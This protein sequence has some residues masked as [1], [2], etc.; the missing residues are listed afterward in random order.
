MSDDLRRLLLAALAALLVTLP[1]LW[2]LGELSY[3]A[4][5]S[6]THKF[7][8]GVRSFLAYGFDRW[9]QL[10]LVGVYVSVTLLQELCLHH[11]PAARQRL[12]P[13]GGAVLA[14]AATVTGVVL[15]MEHLGHVRPIRPFWLIGMCLK[16]TLWL[17]PWIA[18]GYIVRSVL[19]RLERARL[20]MCLGSLLVLGLATMIYSHLGGVWD[21]EVQAFIADAAAI[22]VISIIAGGFSDFI[23]RRDDLLT[24]TL[25]LARIH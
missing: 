19:M 10:Q 11:W 6:H 24:G 3:A 14:L 15:V 16:T 17:V 8:N 13:A 25:G 20:A 22:P 2:L 12:I 1:C 23:S 4:H 7:G 9:R 5:P 18:Y 21:G